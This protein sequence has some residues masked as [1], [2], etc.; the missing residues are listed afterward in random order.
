[1]P[2]HAPWAPDGLWSFAALKL[3]SVCTR[4]TSVAEYIYSQY[5]EHRPQWK[6]DTH[7]DSHIIEIDL[8]NQKWSVF[9]SSTEKTTWCSSLLSETNISTE[10]TKTSVVWR[11]VDNV[12]RKREVTS[13]D[14][15]AP[16]REWAHTWME[17]LH[18]SS[19][20]PLI[21]RQHH[22]FVS[23]VINVLHRGGFSVEMRWTVNAPSWDCGE[24]RGLNSVPV[25]LN[26]GR[27]YTGC[28]RGYKMYQGRRTS[29]WDWTRILSRPFLISKI[30]ITRG[31]PLVIKGY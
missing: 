12:L 1:M 27:L 9:W 4:N 2:A 19:I 10:W 6:Q 24:G 26:R 28:A 22:E 21:C 31:G 30:P 17:T 20:C 8:F 3:E 23:L 7:T 11:N 5:Q 29:E 15:V 13:C 14:S 16:G 25:S 18:Y